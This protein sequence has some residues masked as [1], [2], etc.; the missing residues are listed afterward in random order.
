M[1]GLEALSP[2]AWRLGQLAPLPEDVVDLVE[3]VPGELGLRGGVEVNP[4]QH[5]RVALGTRGPRIN[6]TVKEAVQLNFSVTTIAAKSTTVG[7]LNIIYPSIK[8]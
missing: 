3:P 6:R 4:F 1:K 7:Y 2:R 5:F 8:I